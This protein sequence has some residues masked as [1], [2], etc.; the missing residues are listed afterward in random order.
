M[1]MVGMLVDSEIN[2]STRKGNTGVYHIF[3]H[4]M[5]TT[6]IT[7]TSYLITHTSASLYVPLLG[8]AVQHAFSQKKRCEVTFRE[9]KSGHIVHVCDAP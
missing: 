5:R 2:L 6:L 7:H 3:V 4:S 8:I 1:L 9:T